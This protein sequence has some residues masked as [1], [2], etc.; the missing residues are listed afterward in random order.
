MPLRTS[1]LR[2][3]TGL[4][5]PGTMTVSTADQLQFDRS[6]LHLSGSWPFQFGA[7]G[8]AQG[9]QQRVI[10]ADPACLLCAL[11]Y[12]RSYPKVVL[13]E[14]LA[15]RSRTGL[16]GD[17]PRCCLKGAN[18]GWTDSIVCLDERKHYQSRLISFDTSDTE[19][20]SLAAVESIRHQQGTATQTFYTTP[21]DSNHYSKRFACAGVD[22]GLEEEGEHAR[23]TTAATSTSNQSHMH[24]VRHFYCSLPFCVCMRHNIQATQVRAHAQ[25]W[26]L[27]RATA[28][29]RLLQLI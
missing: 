14:T 7:L 23:S 22:R 8:T 15:W 5:H 24:M 20:R 1:R 18:S 2:V 21:G 12:R 9:W 26:S 3:R 25:R 11:K 17:C 29:C 13:G 28:Q 27:L 4:C 10:G 19:H 16:V 6:P